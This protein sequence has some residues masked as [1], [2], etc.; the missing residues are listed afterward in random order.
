MEKE[1]KPA[2]KIKGVDIYTYHSVYDKSKG[3]NKIHVYFDLNGTHYKNGAVMEAGS[4]MDD[5]DN[6]V[7]GL[8]DWAKT[9]IKE[10]KS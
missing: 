7:K 6:A 10:N 4:S 1:L 9:I 2:L 3:S 5:F 8:L